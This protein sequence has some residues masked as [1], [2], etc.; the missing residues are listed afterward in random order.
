M[1]LRVNG[2]CHQFLA[3]P[4]LACDQYSGVALSYDFYYF[5]HP[6]HL[7]AFRYDILK[8]VTVLQSLTQGQ[9]LLNQLLVCS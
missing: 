1:A 3:C 2:A 9:V 5:D 6:L 8:A 4:A 7:R